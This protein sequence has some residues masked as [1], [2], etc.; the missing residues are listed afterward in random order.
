MGAPVALTM[1]AALSVTAL[2]L[3]PDHEPVE[4]TG[5]AQPTVEAVP[6]TALP[7]PE[8]APVRQRE[9]AGDDRDGAVDAA[10]LAEYWGPSP[11]SPIIGVRT[12]TAGVDWYE[13]ADGSF[14]TTQMVMRSDLGRMAAMTRVAHPR[15]E[16]TPLAGPGARR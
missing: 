2:S 3:L 13:H 8:S 15:H 4:P 7:A 11:W 10:P 14:S 5:V 12:S 16:A 9:P 6:T 1:L